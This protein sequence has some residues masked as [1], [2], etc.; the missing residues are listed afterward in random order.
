MKTKI[1]RTEANLSRSQERIKELE[2][3][4]ESLQNNKNCTSMDLT[5]ISGNVTALNNDIENKNVII[6]RLRQQVEWYE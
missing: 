6:T 5:L 4:L 3:E 2:S 1:E